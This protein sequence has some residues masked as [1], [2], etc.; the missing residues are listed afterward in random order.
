MHFYRVVLFAA[1]GLVLGFTFFFKPAPARAQQPQQRLVEEV[2]I[3]GNRRLRKDD[4]IYYIQT[5]AGDPYNPA[6]VE[7]DL[8]AIL[9]LGFFDK[10]APASR[11]KTRRAVVSAWSLKSKSYRSFATFSSKD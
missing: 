9:A 6:Q 3:I 7:R 8:Q 11:S 1:I 10:S 5:R 2:D 4:I